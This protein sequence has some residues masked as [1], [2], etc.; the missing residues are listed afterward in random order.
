MCRKGHEYCEMFNDRLLVSDM[1]IKRVRVRSK[2]IME[3]NYQELLL[4]TWYVPV[5]LIKIDTVLEHFRWLSSTIWLPFLKVLMVLLRRL[6]FARLDSCSRLSVLYLNTPNQGVTAYK[7]VKQT[8]L[9]VG[10][11]VAI[12]GAGGGLGHLGTLTFHDFSLWHWQLSQLFNTPLRWA[13]ASSLLVMFPCK[14][15]RHNVDKNTVDTGE[16]KQDLCLKLGA[17][18]FVDFQSSDVVKEVQAITDGLGSHGAVITADH[19][20]VHCSFSY[21]QFSRNENSRRLI[22]KLSGTFASLA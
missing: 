12:A 11:W 15:S 18:K 4:N 13:S 19:V 2:L 7:S 3:W 9:D 14:A 10:N 20:S 1:T 21:N 6:F 22:I 17:E 8:N 16:K 5:K